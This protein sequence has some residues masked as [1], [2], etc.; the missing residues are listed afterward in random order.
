MITLSEAFSD[1]A[2]DMDV[3]DRRE[4][5]HGFLFM[6]FDTL[7]RRGFKATLLPNI[8]PVPY[9]HAF[10][11]KFTDAEIREFKPKFTPPKRP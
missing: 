8:K 2:D 4:A 7:T 3:K 10:M 9:V 11:D 6:Q 5:A 1:Y